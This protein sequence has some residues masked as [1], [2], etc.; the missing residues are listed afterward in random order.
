[1]SRSEQLINGINSLI[2]PELYHAAQSTLQK[3][4]TLPDPI[5]SYIHAWPSVASGIAVIVNR[6]TRP[7]KDQN[8]MNSCY[9]FLMTA[10]EYTDC[11]LELGD[12]NMKLEYLPGGV[13]AI[14]GKVLKHGVGGWTGGD[15]ICVSHYFR[16]NVF[17]RMKTEVP[18][19][20]KV[21]SFTSLMDS[22]YTEHMKS[23]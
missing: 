12:L 6:G 18:E 15:R 10:G 8:G 4:T 17:Y 5:P 21:S 16:K 9:D 22:V 23:L 20:V 1:M 14:C 11:H 3:M 19:F 13:V 7:H 2:A